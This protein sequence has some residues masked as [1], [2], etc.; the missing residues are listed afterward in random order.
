[1]KRFVWIFGLG[2]V[3]L[4]AWAIGSAVVSTSLVQ[5]SKL[6]R[7]TPRETHLMAQRRAEAKREGRDYHVDCRWVSYERISPLLRHAVLV[8]EDDKFFSHD[9]L[10]WNELRNAAKKDFAERRF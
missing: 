6:A 8:A 2:L 4:I 3:A 5:V 7:T 10:D 1:M 9:G